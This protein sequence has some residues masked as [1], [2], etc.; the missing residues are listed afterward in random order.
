LLSDDE[1]IAQARA[2][3]AEID[4]MIQLA[5]HEGRAIHPGLRSISGEILRLRAEL[6]DLRAMRERAQAFAND[7]FN[8]VSE[9]RQD[10]AQ[11]ILGQ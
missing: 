8:Q 4:G 6:T 9:L 5:R 11:E 1:L 2:R 7:E 3:P 10:T